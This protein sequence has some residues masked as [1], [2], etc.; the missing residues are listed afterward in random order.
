MFIQS[1]QSRGSL[2][3]STYCMHMLYNTFT[4]MK[5]GSISYAKR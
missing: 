3:I 4:N 1:T 2:S 5:K